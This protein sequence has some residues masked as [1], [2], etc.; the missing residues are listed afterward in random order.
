[1]RYRF[2]NWVG[3]LVLLAAGVVLF[4][5]GAAAA[6][7]TWTGAV[8]TDWNVAGNWS[9]ASVP[10]GSDDV[11]INGSLTNY[12]VIS[13]AA[14]AH[15][16]TINGGS[17]TVDP[18]VTLA[19]T[20]NI[21]IKSGATLDLGD[22]NLTV[23]KSLNIEGTLNVGS[24][25]ITMGDKFNLNG[26]TFNAGTGTVV[27]TES[28]KDIMGDPVTFYN[29]VINENTDGLT[30]ITVLGD[31][32]IA[33]G[34]TLTMG[35]NTLTVVGNILG[36]GSISANA[37]YMTTIGVLST[38]QVDVK[39]S[40][41]VSLATSQN[42]ANYGVDNGVSVLSAVR[43]ASDNSLVHLTLSTLADNTTYQLTVSNVQ[44]LGGT[45][46][47]PGSG[48]NF[49]TD[50]IFVYRIVPSASAGGS[51]SPSDTVDV[52]EGSDTSFTFTPDAG[53]LVSDVF[54]DSVSVGAVPSYT[55]TN[56]TADH[57]IHAEFSVRTFPISA[58]AGPNGSVTP[59][60]VTQVDYD[61]SQT[62]TITPNTGYFV[63]DVFVDSVSVGATT[64]YTFNNVTAAHTIEAT[65]ALQSFTITTSAGPNG[66][67]SPSGSTVVN[68]GDTLTVAITPDGGY[69]VADVFVDSVSVGATGQFVF[70]HVTADH[71]LMATFGTNT[72]PTA[73]LLASPADGD[74]VMAGLLGAVD[75]AWHPAADADAGDTLRYT[76]TITG[77]GVDYSAGDLADTSVT[78][79]LS[80]VLMGGDTYRW[81]VLVSDGATT[82]A[83]PDT[84][85]FMVDP[86]TAVREERGIPTV[87]ALGQN[88]PNP[89][90]PTTS[91]PFDL[92]ERSTVTLKVYNILGAEVLN[93]LSAEKLQAGAYR[94]EVDFTSLPT[95]AYFY[96]ITAGG[97]SGA[98]FER[99]M[100]LVVLK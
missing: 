47:A 41:S 29:L 54:V 37:P 65:F 25:T 99:V 22:G 80:S 79:D 17:V 20:D 1:M 51:V 6:A 8:S 44:D 98:V 39:F 27:M 45:T 2:F 19:I 21:T 100:K 68:Y 13:A 55:F 10:T 16:M 46:I 14:T 38:T 3:K 28:N 97:E 23:A 50:F 42:A 43:D 9:P 86:G 34:K 88:Y 73:P 89:F 5:T 62:Y 74:T 87:F 95:G 61:G 33:T 40:E 64:S 77:P 57:R 93:L 53:Y 94:Q 24:G 96:R 70:A 7:R 48:K 30:D 26:G 59:A 90:N 58:T 76:L 15:N 84:F 71:T 92:P 32:T 78:L 36:G 60:G 56:V 4:S 81:T 82:T 66:S 69:F 49:V 11:T 75:F 18:G 52:V 85:T 67:V 35:A 72:P 12:P 83:S 31:L 63:S 91:I